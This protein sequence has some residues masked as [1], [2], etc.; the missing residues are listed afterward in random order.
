MNSNKPVTRKTCCWELD[1]LEKETV[2]GIFKAI[3]EFERAPKIQELQSSLKKPADE[4]IRVIDGLEEKDLLLRKKG[5]QE[6]ISIYP[7]SLKP[8]QHQVI[9]EN[10]KKLF[11]MCA[12]DAVGIPSLFNLNA[13]VNSRCE[14]CTEKISIEIKDIEIAAKSHPHILIWNTDEIIIPAAE[15]CCPLVNFFCTQEHLK[16]WEG[17]NPDI[18]KI[19]KG[20]PLE[21]A[22]PEN[23]DR[24]KRYGEMIGIR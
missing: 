22:Y 8:T 12:L 17:K 4:I 13:R 11:A 23:R 7:V 21:K 15:T 19:G 16:E 18:S 5:T 1:P 2:N 9:L 24:W 6:I 14:W 3:L 20:I 10:G